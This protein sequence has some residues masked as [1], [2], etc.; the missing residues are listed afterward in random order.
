MHHIKM[1]NALSQVHH[2]ECII[3]LAI[4]SNITN[5]L[6]K[7]HCMHAQLHMVEECSQAIMKRNTESIKSKPF[8]ERKFLQ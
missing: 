5:E 7:S 6:H 8:R 1:P 3:L 2:P 4:Y